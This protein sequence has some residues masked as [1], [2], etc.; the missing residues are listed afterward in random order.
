MKRAIRNDKDKVTY[1]SPRLVGGEIPG[2]VVASRK[3]ANEIS[4]MLRPANP[5]YKAGFA[6]RFPVKSFGCDL[7]S[8]K[9]LSKIFETPLTYFLLSACRQVRGEIFEG[10]FL[11]LGENLQI[12]TRKSLRNLEERLFSAFFGHE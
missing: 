1:E 4:F 12:H 2:H 11:M 6:G 8:F 7:F 10:L 3:R 5:A 9:P